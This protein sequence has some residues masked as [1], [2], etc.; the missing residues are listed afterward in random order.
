M[1]LKINKPRRKNGKSFFVGN[2]V[3]I[4]KYNRI[5]IVEYI[6][7]GKNSKAIIRYNE[8]NYFHTHKPLK[9]LI[10]LNEK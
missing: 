3:L 8:N 2:R 4:L 1:Q 6:D 10:L 5:G 9:E 7:N